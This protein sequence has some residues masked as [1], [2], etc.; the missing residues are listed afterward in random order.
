MT[1][2]VHVVSCNMALLL[3]LSNEILLAIIV[4]VHSSRSDLRSLSRVCRRLN[5]C[6]GRWIFAKYRLN[7][8]SPSHYRTLTNLDTAQT[9]ISWNLDAVMARINHFRAKAPYVKDLILEDQRRD[10]NAEL[11][12]FP[13]CIIP[14]L[15][16]ALKGANRVA[17]IEVTCGFGGTLPLPLWEW[18]TTKDLMML[19]IGSLLAPPPG[20]M[21]HPKVRS[22]EGGLFKESMPFLD[23]SRNRLCQSTARS[24]GSS[25]HLSTIDQITLS[26]I[27]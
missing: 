9:V 5:A 2:Q 21:M 1:V 23:V 7:L 12:H 24:T 25:A 17:R 20:A 11:G 27:L 8:R 18:I 10:D 4:Y 6:S 3:D 16:D 22:F 15:L 26:E 13:E 19:K 14:D